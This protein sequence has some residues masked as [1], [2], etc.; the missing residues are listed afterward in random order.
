MR[1]TERHNPYTAHLKNQQL[2]TFCSGTLARREHIYQEI[3]AEQI[4]W[5]GKRVLCLM[6]GI[7]RNADRLRALGATVTNSDIDP[8]V[9]ELGRA[10]YPQIEHRVY[11]VYAEPIT[12]Y[13]AVINESWWHHGRI[14]W[15]YYQLMLKWQKHTQV[16]PTRVN[17]RLYRFDS[18][19]LDSFYQQ[20]EDAGTR[21]VAE[22]WQS[23]AME[24]QLSIRETEQ[25]V[26]EP[27]I[28][29]TA[30]WHLDIPIC[31]SHSYQMLGYTDFGLP[32]QYFR[33]IFCNNGLVLKTDSARSS[34]IV[35]NQTHTAWKITN[36]SI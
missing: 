12:G 2:T 33:G 22:S 14:N 8:A 32:D 35:D 16:L 36:E 9:I 24:G 30:D 6:G 4:N 21:Y 31:R 1:I 19:L 27:V 15:E 11:D 18:P 23:L 10:V 26:T 20:A 29:N 34:L 7:G 17:L 25:L 13:D 3:E 28:L 5:S